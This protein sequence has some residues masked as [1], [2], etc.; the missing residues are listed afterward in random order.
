MGILKSTRVRENIDWMGIA[1]LA[2][3]GRVE[4]RDRG[5]NKTTEKY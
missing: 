3:N 2:R 1:T 5:T 4:R